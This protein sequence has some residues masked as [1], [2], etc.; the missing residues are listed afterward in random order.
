MVL[1]WDITIP[2]KTSLANGVLLFLLS[3]AF[4]GDHRVTTWKTTPLLAK[5]RSSGPVR[6]H[7]FM[8][9]LSQ[10]C[11]LALMFVF[12]GVSWG[13]RNREPLDQCPG[14]P[15]LLGS[16]KAASLETGK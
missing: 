15:G 9:W 16:S 4:L 3:L 5:L 8:L 2:L 7:S 6:A 11:L 12:G 10:R 1:F 13:P 14:E